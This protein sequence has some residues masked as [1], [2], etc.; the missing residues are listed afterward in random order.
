MEDTRVPISKEKGFFQCDAA[1]FR[2]VGNALTPSEFLVWCMIGSYSPYFN[3]THENICK[4]TGLSD[5]TVK[6]CIRGLEQKKYAVVIR[7][8]LESSTKGRRGG[9][10]EYKY[11]TFDTPKLCLRWLREQMAPEV[12]NYPL[13]TY[14]N[15]GWRFASPK[16]WEDYMSTG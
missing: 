16:N 14:Y 6:T 12:K 9:T 10:F 1:T 4:D 15:I 8:R 11:K 3:P 2:K 13:V 5:S 7:R